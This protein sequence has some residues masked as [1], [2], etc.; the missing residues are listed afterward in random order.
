MEAL[1]GGAVSYEQGTQVMNTLLTQPM[2]V[3]ETGHL[4]V[5]SEDGRH[6]MHGSPKW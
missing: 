2:D 5:V 6:I 3:Y 4:I 1:W